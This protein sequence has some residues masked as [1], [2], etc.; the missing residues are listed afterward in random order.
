[1]YFY[2]FRVLLEA[3]FEERQDDVVWDFP[4]RGLSSGSADKLGDLRKDL[5]C[6]TLVGERPLP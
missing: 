1:M 4:C 2:R 3:D 6:L 5:F